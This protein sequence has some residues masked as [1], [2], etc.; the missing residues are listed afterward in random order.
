MDLPFTVLAQGD[1]AVLM[2]KGR[3][4]PVFYNIVCI[5]DGELIGRIYGPFEELDALVGLRNLRLKLI[6]GREV[7]VEVSG[8]YLDAISEAHL[9]FP[10]GFGAITN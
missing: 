4:T 1:G 7:A 10:D 6:D 8:A 9:I 3:A 5:K 2:E